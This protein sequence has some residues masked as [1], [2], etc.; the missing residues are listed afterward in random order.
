MRLLAMIT[1]KSGDRAKKATFVVNQILNTSNGVRARVAEYFDVS[2][3]YIS[4]LLN[5]G[6]LHSQL[7]D[8]L[9][10]MGYMKKKPP[11]DPRPRVWIRTDDVDLAV[12]Q[13]LE[14]YELGDIVESLANTTGDIISVEW[15]VP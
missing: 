3:P 8:S 11:I 1:S 14:H 2:T 7:D 9:V 15:R 12:G 10:S 4:F 13:L 5:K 6:E